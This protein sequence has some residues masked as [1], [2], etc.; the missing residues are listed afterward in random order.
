MLNKLCMKLR[1]NEKKNQSLASLV[2]LD[3]S[4]PLASHSLLQ[5]W[6][7]SSYG[8]GVEVSSL[9]QRYLMIAEQ[10]SGCR[11]TWQK[12]LVEAL[13]KSTHVGFYYLLLDLCL[14]EEYRKKGFIPFISP[15]LMGI[16]CVSVPGMYYLRQH[17][18]MIF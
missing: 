16:Q 15:E 13:G 9:R 6:L 2:C 10:D 7:L 17:I 12:H 11:S 18:S 4:F 5:F 3:I 8:H 1:W 14:L